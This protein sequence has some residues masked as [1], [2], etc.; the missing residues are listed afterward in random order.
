MQASEIRLKLIVVLSVTNAILFCKVSTMPRTCA[1]LRAPLTWWLRWGLGVVET[2]DVP[3]SLFISIL[4]V[5]VGA[6]WKEMTLADKVC[7]S[8]HV[9]DVVVHVSELAFFGTG[10]LIFECR[11]RLASPDCLSWRVCNTKNM[12]KIQHDIDF[13]Y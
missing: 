8:Y 7:R 11:S 5:P 3:R 10:S 2:R 12:S 9:S 4:A 13:K 1:E 6:I